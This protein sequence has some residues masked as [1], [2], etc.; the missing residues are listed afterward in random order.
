MTAF[1]MPGGDR[2]MVEQGDPDGPRRVEPSDIVGTVVYLHRR[3]SAF[4][5]G[6]MIKLDG[7]SAL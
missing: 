6:A 3:A 1:C 4:T 2:S 5:T 7:G